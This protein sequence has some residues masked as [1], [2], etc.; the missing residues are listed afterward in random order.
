MIKGIG[1]NTKITRD[2]YSTIVRLHGTP[3][4]EYS[5]QSGVLVLN[6]GGYRTATTKRRINEVANEW[7]LGFYVYQKAK[8]WY[9][10]SDCGYPAMD[11]KKPIPFYDGIKLG[12][13]CGRIIL[14]IPE[15]FY[16]YSS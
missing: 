16:R 5:A 4:V 1:R 3:V 6:S 2:G 9:I 8:E 14:A 15:D 11:W 13:Y 10:K 7:G 12:I